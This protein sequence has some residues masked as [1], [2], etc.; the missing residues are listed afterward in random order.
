MTD[1]LTEETQTDFAEGGASCEEHPDN[2]GDDGRRDSASGREWSS[3]AHRVRHAR[4]EAG[5]TQVE[6]ARRMGKSQ[7]FV[8]QAE[9]GVNRIGPRYVDEVLKACG[10]P[11]DWGAP[12]AVGADGDESEAIIARRLMAESGWP[13]VY[14]R[15]AGLDPETFEPVL[16]DSARD[17][18]LRERYHWWTG[19]PSVWDFESLR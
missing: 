10:L 12:A 19:E 2:G 16:R 15:Y 3:L 18:E 1:N 13:A 6:L 14:A 7:A 17:Q 4:K 8:S 11:A 5:V 9:T